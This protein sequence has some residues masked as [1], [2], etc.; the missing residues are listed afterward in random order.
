MTFNT[1]A[2]PLLLGHR[3]CRLTGFKESFRSA[4]QYALDS[5]CHGFEF[6]VRR[7]RDGKLICVHDPAV[8][9]VHIGSSTYE[10]ISKHY[11][12]KKL[13]QESEAIPCLDDVLDEFGAT[14]FLDIEL[15]APGYEP[16]VIALL[17]KTP[18]TV[19]YV[20]SS[21]LPEVICRIAELAPDLQLGYLADDLGPLRAWPSM[22]GTYVIP[23]HDLLTRELVDAVHQ[24]GRKVI[25]WTVN[26][27]DDMLRFADWGVDGLISDDPALLSSTVGRSR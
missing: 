10:T 7:T 23:R 19:G 17:R 22:P 12:E 27:A 18:P 20:V 9:Q 2:A 25:I 5:N 8:Q 21:F 16:A 24:S 11:F 14:A 3:G 15:K 26:N 6:D 13:R 4:F 1:H